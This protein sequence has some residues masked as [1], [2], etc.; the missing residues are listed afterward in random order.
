MTPETPR[1]RRLIFVNRYYRPDQSATSQLLTDLAQSLAA[2]GCEVHV[3]CSRQLYEDPDVRL[4]PFE[5]LCL[6]QVHRVATTRF[7]RGRLIG[8]AIDYASFYASS[9]IAL[10]R[11][12]RRADVLIP[13]TDPPLLS[14]LAALIARM[15]GAALVNWQQDVFP[16]IASHLGSNPLPG[17]LDRLLR[18]A[19]DASLRAARMNVV[20]GHRM[21]EYFAAQKIP[22]AQLCV[23]DNWAD[24]EAIVAKPAS[25]SALGARLRLAGRFVVGYSGNL[26]R[27]HEYQTLLS[28]AEILRGDPSFAFLMIGGGAKMQAL[29]EAVAQRGLEHF[30]FLGYQAREELSDSLAAADVHLA[31]LLP[32]LEGLL[33]PS[34]LYGVLA[35]G[36]PLVFIGDEDGE[37]A[38]IL[39]QYGC[40]IVVG[41][42]AGDTLAAALR[43]LQANP[44]ECAAM[45]ARARSALVEHYSRDA[46]LARWAAVLD[47]TPANRR[48]DVAPPAPSSR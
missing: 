30:L 9:A 19:R 41:V 35:A 40:G 12:V 25:A 2:R 26:G 32:E 13:K 34:K 7:G 8:R 23:I 47:L 42:G 11:L 46:A 45:G 36:R 20:V 3:V 22:A 18:R 16:E 1:P 4:E 39:H 15:K 38:R 44:E 17:W 48:G 27:A 29:R 37:I 10:M 31:S 21:Q 5:V 24:P 14:I 43:R 33:V 28:A 6:V